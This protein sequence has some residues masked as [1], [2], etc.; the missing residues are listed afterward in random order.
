M[1]II[2]C[3][4]CGTE[5]CF[6][7][8]GGC[9]HVDVKVLAQAAQEVANARARYVLSEDTASRIKARHEVD[10][11]EKRLMDR[12]FSIFGREFLKLNG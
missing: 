10:R 5:G 1:D 11:T 3:P 12:A 9:I 4:A 8:G 7:E 6:H 2:T